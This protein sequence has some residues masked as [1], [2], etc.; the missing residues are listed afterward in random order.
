MILISSEFDIWRMVEVEAESQSRLLTDTEEEYEFLERYIESSKPPY[1][2][3]DHHFLIRTSFRYEA[4]TPPEYAG[5]FKE[6]MS[7][8]QGLYGSVYPQTTFY[9]VAFH[10]LRERVHLPSPTQTPEPRTLFSVS[11]QDSAEHDIASEPNIAELTS[12]IDYSAS[13]QFVRNHPEVRS[14][15]YPSCRCPQHGRNVFTRDIE[16]L[17]R[18]PKALINFNLILRAREKS[19]YIIH[20]THDSRWPPLEISWTKVC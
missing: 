4:P 14:I 20:Q 1:P 3:G 10:W 13:W 15:I 2:P 8:V 9:E 19:C 12:R 18:T 6:P 11:F 5:R 7:N 17:G 16:T